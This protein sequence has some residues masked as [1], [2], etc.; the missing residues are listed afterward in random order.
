MSSR[1]ARPEKEKAP[2]G[3]YSPGPVLGMHLL[4]QV[5]SAEPGIQP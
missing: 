1:I 2:G 5:D 3:Y 4:K